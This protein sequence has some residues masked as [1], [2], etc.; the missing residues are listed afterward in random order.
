[1]NRRVCVTHTGNP[2]E[3]QS[4]NVQDMA[5]L[6]KQ[7]G[8]VFLLVP[9]V[10]CMHKHSSSVFCPASAQTARLREHIDMTTETAR[11][12]DK[13]LLQLLGLASCRLG[14]MTIVTLPSQH[15]YLD[16]N[17][18]NSCLVAHLVSYLA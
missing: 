1:M 9:K 18:H 12:S 11:P 15:C 13:P 14:L 7:K 16:C 5:S 17:L 4:C 3:S 10:G 6:A 2:G 8:D